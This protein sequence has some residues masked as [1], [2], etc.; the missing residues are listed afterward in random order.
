MLSYYRALARRLRRRIGRVRASTTL[1]WGE[2]DVALS[3]ALA[4][5][6][7]GV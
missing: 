5:A 2:W 1:V 7:L 3:L 4:E 6:S